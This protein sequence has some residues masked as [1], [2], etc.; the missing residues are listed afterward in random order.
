MESTGCVETA[1]RMETW[2]TEDGQINCIL[3][4]SV[5]TSI[6]NHTLCFS[7]L[8]PCEVTEGAKVRHRTASYIELHFDQER[9][10]AGQGQQFSL[11]YE[12]NRNPANRSWF[13]KG[14]YLRLQDSRILPVEIIRVA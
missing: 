13:P 4:A 2:R 10:G 8:A 9:L 6:S 1:I 11:K 12:G 7:M 14:A 3:S 5:D